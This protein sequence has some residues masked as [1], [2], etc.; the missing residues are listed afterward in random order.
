MGQLEQAWTYPLRAFNTAVP[1][2]VNGNMYMTAQNRVV[3]L[4]AATGEEVWV[5]ETET[6]PG[7]GGFSGRGVGYW[8]GEGDHVHLMVIM[9]LASFTNTFIR[10][11]M[12]TM[13]K[14]YPWFASF[15]MGD[16]G[17]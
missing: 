6:G 2:V 14:Y 15:V 17:K 8:P 3:A 4:N 5:H 9:E 7:V 1:V 12:E 11:L 16:C 13:D 10:V